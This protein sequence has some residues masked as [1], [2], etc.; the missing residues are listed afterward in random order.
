MEKAEQR[1]EALKS[2]K[3]EVVLL[4]E[5]P[6]YIFRVENKNL[7]VIGEGSHFAK[8]MFI[9]EAPGRNEAKT[10]RP[11]C[12]AAG[13]IL[14][15]LLE[16]A[17]IKREEVYVTN[18]VKDRPPQNRDPLPSEI[19]LYGPFLDR[20][21]E[22][23]QPRVIATLGRYAMGYVMNKF[24]L[25]LELEPIGKMHGRVFDTTLSYGPIKVVPLYHPAVAVYNSHTKDQLKDDFKVL[26]NL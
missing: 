15:E 10:G 22:I 21:I 25:E 19:E 4:K 9:G 23:I 3:D 16:S 2:I 18:I 1:H 5:S 7:P 12:G 24:G 11:F 6:L 13:K 26:K 17:G 14:D 8:I 20:Q